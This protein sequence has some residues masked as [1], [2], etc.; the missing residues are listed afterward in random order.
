MAAERERRPMVVR[1]T[2]CGKKI[3]ERLPNGIWRFIFGKGAEGVS[4]PPV[5]MQIHG[6]LKM[7]CLRRSCRHNKPDHWNVLNFFPN[8]KLLPNR[9][10][11]EER[12]QNTIS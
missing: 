1:C 12:K 10:E 7:R 6:S 3:I 5:E 4:K 2:V 11:S 9:S 8:I